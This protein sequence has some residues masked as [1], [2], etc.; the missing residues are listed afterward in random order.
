MEGTDPGV[1]HF[2]AQ[3]R[4]GST[5]P[6]DGILVTVKTFDVTTALTSIAAAYPQI[7][8]V[9]LPQNGL[10]IEDRARDALE[11][12]GRSRAPLVRAIASIPATLLGPGR[13][14]AAGAGEVLVAAHPAPAVEAATRWFAELLRSGGI[15][16]R[17]VEELRREEWRKLLVNAAINP[18][19][20]DHGILNGRLAE[21]P[22]RSQALHLLR[23]ARDAAG[24]DGV[25]F[26]E[27]E[28]E[29]DLFRVVRGTADNRSSML[30]D[31]ERGRPTEIEAISGAVLRVAW[32][33]GID[34]PATRRAVDRILEHVRSGDRRRAPQ[35]S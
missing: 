24:L 8:P 12:A 23:E 6:P 33:H 31:L 30:Q 11:A 35:G 15:P 16:V 1:V 29:R 19:T 5:E 14:R 2:D 18:V 17:E 27:S 34:L 25:V 4:L 21:D 7:P 10:G 22:W 9:L 28:V 20:A 26:D 3:E 32:K 13:I